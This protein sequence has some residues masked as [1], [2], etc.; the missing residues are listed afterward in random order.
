MKSRMPAA[1]VDAGRRAQARFETQDASRWTIVLTCEL[2]ADDTPDSSGLEVLR[3]IESR[4]LPG[5]GE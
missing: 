5:S 4:I 2:S 1:T 3:V